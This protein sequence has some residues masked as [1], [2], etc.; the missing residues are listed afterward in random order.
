MPQSRLLQNY[1]PG[2]ENQCARDGG[3]HHTAHLRCDESKA[4]RVPPFSRFPRLEDPGP[5][6]YQRKDD[7]DVTECEG[8]GHQACE[9]FRITPSGADP[10]RNNCDHGDA[11]TRQNIDFLEQIRRMNVCAADPFTHTLGFD[12]LV[13]ADMCCGCG[14][15]FDT[16]PTR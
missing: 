7:E 1:A 13:L 16:P 2:P 4:G 14:H 5:H 15:V 12:R 8:Y 3:L 9:S 10:E 11:L 6:H